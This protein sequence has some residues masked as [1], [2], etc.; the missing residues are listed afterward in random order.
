MLVAGLTGNYGMGKSLVLSLFRELGAATIDSDAVVRSLLEEE[1]VIKGVRGI[2][3]E[4]VM[5]EGGR[6]DKKNVAKKIFKNNTLRAQVENLL[7]PLVFE[8]I[9]RFVDDNRGKVAVAVVEVPLLFEGGYEKRFDLTVVVYAR[10]DV[11]LKRL[12][13]SGVTRS[14]AQRRLKAQLPITLKKRRADYVIDNSGSTGETRRQVAEIYDCLLREK[15][16]E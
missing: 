13:H 10:R 11:A 2:L 6:L 4:E 15:G 16:R 14:E 7:H 5:A 3:G 9:Q 8:R 12:A 1:A